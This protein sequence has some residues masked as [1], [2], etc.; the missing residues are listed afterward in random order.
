[1][2]SSMNMTTTWDIIGQEFTEVL[3][4]EMARLKLIESD[5]HGA[6]RLAPKIE[7]VFEL[8]P[9]TLLNCD[10]ILSKSFV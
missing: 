5:K 1:M 3:K 9:I 6:T 10:S 7:G 2:S 4:V 8:R